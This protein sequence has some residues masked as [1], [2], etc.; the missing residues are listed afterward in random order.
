MAIHAPPGPSELGKVQILIHGSPDPR[1]ER[2]LI[3]GAV[4]T[5]A[6]TSG[7]PAV[8]KAARPY[9]DATIEEISEVY[10]DDIL[11]EMKLLGFAVP[12]SLDRGWATK[13]A[14]AEWLF[15]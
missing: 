4:D 3:M 12:E 5:E 8:F 13:V 11:R 2:G 10:E 7:V 9:D 15:D 14:Q 1:D 6:G